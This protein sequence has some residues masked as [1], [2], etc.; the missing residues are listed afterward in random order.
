LRPL[1]LLDADD[2]WQLLLLRLPSEFQIGS[3]PRQIFLML[4]SQF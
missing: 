2:V 3:P 4:P 1:L